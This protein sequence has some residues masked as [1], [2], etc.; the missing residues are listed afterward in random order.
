MTNRH[1]PLSVF[2]LEDL[3]PHLRERARPLSDHGL[4]LP[5]EFVLY[6]M[7]AALRGHENPALD[8]ALAI[9][10]HLEL[11][12]LVYQGL[13][14]RYPF[15]SDRHHSFI[16]EG[17]R[18]V[19]AELGERGITYAFH[20]EREGRDAAFLKQLCG[21]AAAVVTEDLPV[22]PLRGWADQ[23][24]EAIEPP[25]IAFDT[26]CVVPM[27]LTRRAYDRAFAF[28]KATDS[29][30]G[31]RLGRRWPERQ[32]H[33]SADGVGL[34]FEPLDL[35]NA[36]F[37][38]LLCQCRIDHGVPP[39]PQTRGGS[40]A[41]YRR[42]EEFRDGQGLR[43]YA[44]RRNDALRPEAVSRLSPYLHY[45]MVSP[46]RI[47]REALEHGS[48][49]SRK[50][51]DEL[52]V[53]REL[54]YHFCFHRPDHATLSAIPNWARRTL[55]DREGDRRP[56]LL[57]TE[58]LAR[59]RSGDELWDA[60][61]M[62]LL[63]QGELH[64]NV[65]MTWGKALLS[66]TPNA[67]T[68][69][70]ELRDLNHRYAL[71]GRD[72]SSYGGILW[73]LGQFDRPFPPEKPI[74]GSVR[75]RPTRTHAKRLDVARYRR[76][77][78]EPVF[79]DLPR[80]LVVGAG[81]AGLACARTLSDQGIPVTV[82]DKGRGPGG[83]ISTRREADSA[84]YDHGAQFF[85]VRDRRFDRPVRAWHQ[86]GVVAPWKGTVVTLERG[87]KE[88]ARPAER[89][90]GTPGMSAL[91]AH[92]A[93]DLEVL[94]GH[95]VS[96]LE[97]RGSGW[98]A[99]TDGGRSLEADLCILTAP[100]PQSL[101]LL[102][103]GSALAQKLEGVTYAPC[104]ALMLALEQPMDVPYE[105][106]FVED[107]A[108]AWIARDS[109][110]PGRGP[111]ERWVLHATPSWSE[112][113]LEADPESLIPEMLNAFGKATT[114]PVPQVIASRAFRWRYALVT[115]SLGVDHLFDA[116]SGLGY[117]GDACLGSRVEQAYLS[118]VA[119]AGRLM[120]TLAAGAPAARVERGKT[121]ALPFAGAGAS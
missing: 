29:L 62:S 121:L 45:G 34:P 43:N 42:W 13:S 64:N 2:H 30:R 70:A 10:D 99:E 92:L 24:A 107:S 41:G 53:W 48:D 63:R 65:R 82:V 38:E 16:L 28:R 40:R 3:P 114:R 6:W 11:P 117:A 39:V 115:Q 52:L 120:R 1:E 56:Q 95:Q 12:V 69:L 58:Q 73:C 102:P 33:R 31:E 25:L 116:D 85:T 97:R 108:L 87:Q 18:D 15:A 72:P 89:W 49:G 98:I 106:A 17:A 51:L 46:L 67:E 57:S 109:G 26:S 105:G 68:A 101:D 47:A 71:D 36:D 4:H 7:R 112:R 35:E 54:A 77:T 75:P 78:S 111:G 110:K 88:A 9:A 50:Y 27:P 76:L 91:A 8:G 22:A 74:L 14:E 93:S 83:R 113:H 90:V 37:A 21:R 79:D 119:V 84:R 81:V 80:V 94:R 5:A 59:A 55:A 96:G 103:A 118:G 61:Q 66:W 20:L 104:L 100:T 60:A 86:E 19:A 23:L 32:V 44:R